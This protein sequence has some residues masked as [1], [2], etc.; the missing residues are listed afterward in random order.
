[1]KKHYYLVAID[2]TGK[3]FGKWSVNLTLDIN[4]VNK[5]AMKDCLLAVSNQ[6]GIDQ[7]NLVVTSVS[8]LGEM[9]EEEW[10]Q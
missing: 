2:G 5:K 6:R 3:D 1:M 8:Y 9:T 10:N 7:N 4:F